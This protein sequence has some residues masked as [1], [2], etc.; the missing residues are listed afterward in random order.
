MTRP[1]W[2]PPD[3][4]ETRKFPVV[5]ERAP[6]P[7]APSPEAWTLTLTGAGRPAQVISYSDLTNGHEQH[8]TMDVHCVT[9]WSHREMR[10]IGRPL[11]ELIG[12]GG[13][14]EAPPSVT[15]LRF[16]ADSARGHDTGLPLEVALAQ[17]WLV[18]ATPE[19]LLS[20]EH[21]GPLRTVTLGRYFYKSL[22]FLRAIELLETP[23]LGYWER[24]HGYH[25]VGEPFAG[26]QRFVTGS[27]RPE[28]VQRFV[29]SVDFSPYWGRTLSGLA[30]QGFN[31]ATRLLGAVSL[32][33][34]RLDGAK[35]SGVDLSGANLS[36]SHFDGA[37]LQ[38]ST[39]RG[40][41]LEG[42]FLA[43][44]DLRG[45]DL[46]R[47]LLN[48]AELWN[49][50]SSARVEGAEFAGSTGLLESQLD[51]LRSQPVASLP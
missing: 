47:T 27:V 43:G 35:L 46:R 25:E 17:T 28:V 51:W 3:Q 15:Y 50:Q 32:K 11:S 21:G 24:E 10:F 18:W 19:G 5:G 42:T 4:T 23:R 26:D 44:A 49:E 7:N 14:F 12:P 41:D 40:A 39:L 9:R 29:K 48:G 6:S 2:L 20:T 22:K 37:E 8:L 38:G 34:C 33:N 36:L 31:P 30:L 45:A 16:L 1:S 13:A